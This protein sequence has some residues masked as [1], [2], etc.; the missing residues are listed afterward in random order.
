MS[1]AA[2]KPRAVRANPLRVL[3]RVRYGECDAQGIM[4][5]AR[6]ADHLDILMSELVRA[7]FGSYGAML[8]EKLD[9][10][11]VRCL[12]EW[13]APARFDDVVALSIVRLAFG[14]T[15]FTAEVA[16][17]RHPGGE[18]IARAE[19]VNVMVHTVR[20]RKTPI[21]ASVRERLA[22]AAARG[23]TIDFSG[24]PGVATAGR[25]PGTRSTTATREKP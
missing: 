25:L 18:P 8:E 17:C 22:T 7:A 13:M 2:R 20:K 9:T 21:P 10:H 14:T 19:H 5:N 6:Y 11:V 23:G 1:A 4:F 15:S 3:L 24:G 12:I 16:M